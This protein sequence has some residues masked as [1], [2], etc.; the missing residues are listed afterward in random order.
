MSEICENTGQRVPAV[1]R[2]PTQRSSD[3]GAVGV[4]EPQNEGQG[5]RDTMS[6]GGQVGK[7]D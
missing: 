3:G 7:A 2:T 5:S 4:L 1:G 6:Q